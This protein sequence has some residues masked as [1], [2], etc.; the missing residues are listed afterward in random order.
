MPT[1]REVITKRLI[2]NG[3]FEEQ[4]EEVMALAEE[5]MDTMN[6]NWGKDANSYPAIIIN[7]TWS[8]V[9]LVALK[10]ID[11]NAPEAWFKPIFE[12]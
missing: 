8:N 11:E 2:D 7:L 6:E 9:K 4:A 10:W 3:M 5:S 1:V 12:S